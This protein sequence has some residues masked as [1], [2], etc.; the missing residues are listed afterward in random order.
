MIIWIMPLSPVCP[1]VSLSPFLSFSLSLSTY[2]FVPFSQL[3][4]LSTSYLSYL[5]FF[6]SSLYQPIPLFFSLSIPN[7]IYLSPSLHLSS[8]RSVTLPHPLSFP[9]PL[10]FSHLIPSPLSSSHTLSLTISLQF[11]DHIPSLSLP[12]PFSHTIPLSVGLVNL[13]LLY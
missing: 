5:S 6:S 9:I 8:S 11:S 7:F 3:I 13:V 1:S 12:F 4:P 10:Q 2:L